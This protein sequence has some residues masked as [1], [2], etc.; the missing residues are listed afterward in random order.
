MSADPTCQVPDAT[1]GSASREPWPVS[2]VT[3]RPASAYQP[4]SR[5][6]STG[7]FGP[8]HFQSFENRMAVS[9]EAVAVQ[10]N[11]ES[12]RIGRRMVFLL[13]GS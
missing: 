8:S 7:A 13:Y 11:A 4:R 12:S 6:S 9:A 2:T 1:R 3:S 10:T 5:A